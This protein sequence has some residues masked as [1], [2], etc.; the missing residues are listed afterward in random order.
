MELHPVKLKQL[1]LVE[2]QSL[3]RH[4]LA[5]VARQLKLADVVEASS[6]E[7][8]QLLLE[9]KRFDGLLLAVGDGVASLNLLQ[10]LRMG[11]T[12]NTRGLPLALMAESVDPATIELF[13]TMSPQRILLVPFK[14]KT[15]LEVV[16]GLVAEPPSL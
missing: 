4:T 12:R 5:A 6:Y 13:R 9:T 16:T 1:L 14:V 7:A 15:A 11:K 2:P 3:F 8:A 10:T